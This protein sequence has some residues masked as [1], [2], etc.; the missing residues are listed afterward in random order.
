MRVREFSL[1]TNE[2][3]EFTDYKRSSGDVSIR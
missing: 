2:P 1:P 3:H